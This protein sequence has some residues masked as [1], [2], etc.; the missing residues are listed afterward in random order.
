VDFETESMMSEILDRLE[1]ISIDQLQDVYDY[2]LAL[3]V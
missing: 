2:V 3:E 1:I